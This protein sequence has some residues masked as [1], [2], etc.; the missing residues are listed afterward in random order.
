[1]D[2]IESEL[3]F[4]TSGFSLFEIFATNEVSPSRGSPSSIFIINESDTVTG[5]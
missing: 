4:T 5:G 2:K 3:L 1:M